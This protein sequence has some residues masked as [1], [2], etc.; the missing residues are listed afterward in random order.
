MK[1]KYYA[2]GPERAKRVQEL[3]ARIAFR[4]DLINDLQSLGLHRLWKRRLVLESRIS[5]GLRTL[6]L[7]CGTGDLAV[8]FAKECATVFAC[9]FSPQMLAQARRRLGQD[10]ELVQADALH[11]PFDSQ[12]FDVIAIGYGLRNLADF[13]QGLSEMHRVL[14]RGGRL[15]ILDFGRPANLLWRTLYF[16]YLRVVVPLFGFIFCGDAA[17]YAYIIESLKNY[18]AQQGIAEMLG[19]LGFHVEVT[20]F[21]GGIMSLHAAAKPSENIA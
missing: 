7:C 9:D 3:F 18:P 14:K 17:A 20:N 21:L 5:S 8:R 10:A 4:Y 13:E 15:L 6:D 12:Q 2:P 1:D 16:S 11:L 19:N